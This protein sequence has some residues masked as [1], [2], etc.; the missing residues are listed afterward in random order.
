MPIFKRNRRKRDKYKWNSPKA[1][2]KKVA[3][4]IFTSAN[5][6]RLLAMAGFRNF[7]SYLRYLKN[8][9]IL[10]DLVKALG[11]GILENFAPQAVVTGY[12]ILLDSGDIIAAFEKADTIEKKYNFVKM[13]ISKYGKDILPLPLQAFVNLIEGL[14]EY[15]DKWG[16]YDAEQRAALLQ[17]VAIEAGYE[18]I[19]M[20]VFQLT[21]SFAQ[22]INEVQ[23]SQKARRTGYIPPRERKKP[24]GGLRGK[25]RVDENF[26]RGRRALDYQENMARMQQRPRQKMMYEMRKE[27]R[28]YPPVSG[29]TALSKMSKF[30]RNPGMYAEIL[31]KTGDAKRNMF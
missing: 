12:E 23:K 4:K 3:K 2:I 22:I 7:Q 17:K 15:K 30:D 27:Q 8:N 11:V 10:F 24:S 6:A 5:A 20:W 18:T 14:M 13:L 21:D 31:A 16:E 9:G 29:T 1:V 19:P 26:D 25:M 28:N